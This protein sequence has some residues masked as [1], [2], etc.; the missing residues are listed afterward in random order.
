MLPTF[1]IISIIF[2]LKSLDYVKT[3]LPYFKIKKHYSII[4]LS[5]LLIEYIAATVLRT[6]NTAD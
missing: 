5:K 4:F 2:Y 1:F 3:V 6:I